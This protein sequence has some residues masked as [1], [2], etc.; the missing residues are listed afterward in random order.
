[1]MKQSLVIASWGPG[2]QCSRVGSAGAKWGV[3]PSPPPLR[4]PNRTGSLA[5]PPVSMPYTTSGLPVTTQSLTDIFI[6]RDSFE[7][8][9]MIMYIFFK[10]YCPVFDRTKSQHEIWLCVSWWVRYYHNDILNDK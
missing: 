10:V 4:P 1:V 3:P 8:E 7:N 6:I 5:T 2:P 9:K